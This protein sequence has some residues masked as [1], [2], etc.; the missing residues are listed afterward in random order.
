MGYT[1]PTNNMELN[2]NFINIGLSLILKGVLVVAI[3]TIC[4]HG[5]VIVESKFPSMLGV[6]MKHAFKNYT[7]KF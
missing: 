3:L 1:S 7:W 6:V 4:N 2:A 5:M